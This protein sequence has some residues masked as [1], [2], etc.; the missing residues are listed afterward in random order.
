MLRMDLKERESAP[1]CLERGD[2]LW[3]FSENKE[4]ALNHGINNSNTNPQ[5]HQNV[6]FSSR[7]QSD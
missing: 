7:L 2:F 6:S 5:G 4:W 1:G 3:L